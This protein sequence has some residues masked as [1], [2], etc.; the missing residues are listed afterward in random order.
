MARLKASLNFFDVQL[1]A[2]AWHTVAAIK[3]PANAPVQILKYVITGSGIAGDAVPCDVRF[4]RITAD[5]GTGTTTT[6]IKLNNGIDATV[7][8][9]ARV[10]FGGG[11]N[12]PTESGTAPY[13]YPQKF[14]PQSGIMADVTFDDCFV[15]EGT[16][17]AL[18]AYAPVSIDVTGHIV[19]EE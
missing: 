16:E 4:T 8:S 2:G 17:I 7:Q 10:D 5:S 3:A 14:H 13:L 6:P 12:E 11:A 9:V 15:K 18:E 1:A 19:F